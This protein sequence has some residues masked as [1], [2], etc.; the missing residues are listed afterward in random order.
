M[1]EKNIFVYKLFSSLNISD[2]NLFFMWKLTPP[3]L[4]KVT[5]SFPATPSESPPFWKFD[6]RFNPPV[7]MGGG[8]CTLGEG[9]L[10]WSSTVGKT[11]QEKLLKNCIF[12]ATSLRN[13]NLNNFYLVKVRPPNFSQ[14]QIWSTR[15]IIMLWQKSNRFMSGSIKITLHE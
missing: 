6:W 13:K 8:G 10:L 14:R 2:F 11:L 1:T 7:E 12:M 9:G 4:K 5:P 15:Q 3:H